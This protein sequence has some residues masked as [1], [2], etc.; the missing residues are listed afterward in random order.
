MTKRREFLKG[1][2]ALSSLSLAGCGWRLA[3][4][5]ANST[6]ESSRDQLYIYTW[7]QYTDPEL[8]QSF[9]NQFGVK[10]LADVYD[11]NDVMLAKLQAGGGVL[12]ARFTHLTTWCKR[13]LTWGC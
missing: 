5:R 3:E 2:T 10:V 6:S 12:T 11:S 9:T 13:W 4:V 1:V 8:L 7:A